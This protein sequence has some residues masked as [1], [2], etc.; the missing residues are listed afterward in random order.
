MT[1]DSSIVK[2][3]DERSVGGVGMTQIIAGHGYCANDRENCMKRRQSRALNRN[4]MIFLNHKC[5][6]VENVWESEEIRDR[7]GGPN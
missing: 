1:A 2:H 7:R 4:G 5:D 6:H 3:C